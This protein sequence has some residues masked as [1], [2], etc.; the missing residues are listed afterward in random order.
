VPRRAPCG[1]PYPEIGAFLAE[2]RQQDRVA[3]RAL[4]FALL[5][6]AGTGEVIGA[7]WSEINV[8]ERMWTIPGERMKAGKEH[9]VPLSD[10]ALTVVGQM[11]A[12]RQN[13]F[14]FPSIRSGRPLSNMAL[15]MTLRR[16]GRGDLTSHGGRAYWLPGRGR[17]KWPSRTLSAIRSKRPIGGTTCS[18]SARSSPRPGRGSVERPRRGKWCP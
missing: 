3:A 2:L 5:T 4:E 8:A 18:R 6:A 7:R 11:A 16:M 9:R 10:A 15:L 17:P 13:A 12:I 1:A 14:V